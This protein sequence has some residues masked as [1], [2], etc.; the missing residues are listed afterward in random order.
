[1][2]VNCRFYGLYDLEA[3]YTYQLHKDIIPLMMDYKYRPDGWLGI[4]VGT[5]FW[6]DFSERHKLDTNADKLVKELGDRGK[7]AAQET[8]QGNYN[9][10]TGNPLFQAFHIVE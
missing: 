2:L 5:K 4:I 9:H 6:I 3:E 7:I 8:I 1:M 10:V